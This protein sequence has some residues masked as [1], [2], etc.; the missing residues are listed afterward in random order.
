MEAQ[1]QLGAHHNGDFVVAQPQRLE[2]RIFGTCI[3][4]DGIG[5]I[6]GTV[7]IVGLALATYF[8]N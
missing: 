3:C 6:V 1:R 7:I 8:G 2:I 5:G 4:A